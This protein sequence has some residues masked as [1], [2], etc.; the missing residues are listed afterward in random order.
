MYIWTYAFIFFLFILIVA[1]WWIEKTCF[2][3]LIWINK[4]CFSVYLLLAL[5]AGF[6]SPFFLLRSFSFSLLFF[7]AV[8]FTLFAIV[9]LFILFFD[10]VLQIF[11]QF[12]SFASSS[13]SFSTEEGRT[14]YISEKRYDL[15]FREWERVKMSAQNDFTFSRW[16]FISK[17]ITS[18]VCTAR[19]ELGV[20]DMVWCMR[21]KMG[22]YKYI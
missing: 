12:L 22:K 1:C 9:Y 5:H 14:A 8:S 2:S 10:T 11:Q 19:R 21:V 7:S 4:I 20:T 3:Y 18:I 16:I 17:N 6:A 13:S 15:Q